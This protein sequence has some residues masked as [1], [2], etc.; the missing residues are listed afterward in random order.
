M[1]A[2]VVAV[3]EVADGAGGASAPR[4]RRAT[5][6]IFKLKAKRTVEV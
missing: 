6:M 2:G 3:L 5:G 4:N 1:A